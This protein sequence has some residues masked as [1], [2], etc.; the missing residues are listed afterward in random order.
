M[1]LFLSL[2]MLGVLAVAS[3]AWAGTQA[4]DQKNLRFSASSLTVA[5]DHLIEFDNSDDTW[6]NV[7]IVGDG[8]ML[9]SGL[10]APGEPFKVRLGKPGVYNVTCGLHPKM[11]MTVVVD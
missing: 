4:V 8:L 11:K 1:R 5:R 6:H 7:T 9:S 3:V 10:Q 2:G